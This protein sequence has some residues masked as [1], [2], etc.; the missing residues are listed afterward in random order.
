MVVWMLLFSLSSNGQE[1]LVANNNYFIAAFDSYAH[2][3]NYNRMVLHNPRMLLPIVRH[4]S[5][6]QP[7]L[8][9]HIGIEKDPLRGL[10]QM[11][12]GLLMN[13]AT[14]VLCFFQTHSMME[15]NK[16]DICSFNNLYQKVAYPSLNN[17][18]KADYSLVFMKQ[19]QS[20]N[21]TIGYL[22]EIARMGDDYALGVSIVV[23]GLR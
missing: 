6:H 5:K 16:A 23:N 17:V 7:E 13:P 8:R 1:S 20:A 12:N 4:T 18:I 19:E 22:I 21:A 10:A 9:K 11:G 15:P 14:S 3:F 2:E